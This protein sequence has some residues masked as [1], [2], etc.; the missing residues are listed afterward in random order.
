LRADVL[1]AKK[2]LEETMV[3]GML[4]IFPGAPTTG[5]VEVR[6]GKSWADKKG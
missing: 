4:D 6:T 1:S 2:A 5:L 3:A